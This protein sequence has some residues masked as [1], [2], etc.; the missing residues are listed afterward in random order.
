MT[1]SIGPGII[2]TLVGPGGAGK[3]T[4]MKRV[5]PQIDNLY[6]LATAT[7]R[8]MRPGEQ[9][10]REHLFISRDMF[11]QWIEE[12]RLLEYQEVHP[13]KFY[14]VPREPLEEALRDGRNLIA[15]IEIAGAKAI[16]EAYPLNTVLIFIAAPLD[17]LEQRMRERGE[18]EDGV[19]DRMNR[20]KAEMDFA[21]QCHEY[22]L[23]ED[24]DEAAQQ[25]HDVILK[26]RE[27]HKVK[28]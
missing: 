12:N 10:G 9:N 15:D 25:L 1:Q 24:Q 5:I 13:G 3:N 7:T 6:Q 4:L 23:N 20:A 16:A 19:R 28:A 18:S 14:G 11:N 17:A 27:L 8:D 22:I 2:F 21:P 26:W